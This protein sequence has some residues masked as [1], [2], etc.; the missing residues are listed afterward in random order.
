MQSHNH[1]H[2]HQGHIE[3]FHLPEWETT[4]RHRGKRPARTDHKSS[5]I[6]RGL[7][8]FDRVIPR[9]RTYFGFSRKIVCLAAIVVVFLV[10]LALILGLAIGL[11][12]KSR[13]ASPQPEFHMT[14][15]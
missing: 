5:V 13:Y 15:S 7:I 6:E 8:L 4:A 9:H 1:N 2:N 3:D 14:C 10:F 11:S 12:K